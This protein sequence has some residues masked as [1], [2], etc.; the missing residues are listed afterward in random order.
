MFWFEEVQASVPLTLIHCCV[1]RVKLKIMLKDVLAVNFTVINGKKSYQA[2][3]SWETINL[4]KSW[5]KP[6]GNTKSH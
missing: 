5:K 3:K 1:D 4:G 2:S 6:E